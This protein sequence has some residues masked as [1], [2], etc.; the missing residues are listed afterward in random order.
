MGKYSYRVVR[1]EYQRMITS[2]CPKPFTT[3]QAFG[4]LGDQGPAGLPGLDDD[5]QFGAGG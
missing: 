2:L 5:H 3:T 1:E 4:A